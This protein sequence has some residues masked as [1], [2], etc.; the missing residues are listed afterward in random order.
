MVHLVVMDEEETETDQ[1]QMYL[2]SRNQDLEEGSQNVRTFYACLFRML[3][4]SLVTI[5]NMLSCLR[6]KIAVTVRDPAMKNIKL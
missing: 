3:S 1:R 6:W 5:P 2:I 4:L